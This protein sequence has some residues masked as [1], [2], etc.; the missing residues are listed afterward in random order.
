MVIDEIVAAS[1]DDLY[2]RDSPRSLGLSSG[3]CL[4]TAT[5]LI[6]PDSGRHERALQPGASLLAR[7]RVRLIYT[8]SM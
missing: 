2:I 4:R 8:T 3:Y 1:G 7:L 6:E 5:T